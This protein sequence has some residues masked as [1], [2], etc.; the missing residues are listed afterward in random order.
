MKLIPN[1]TRSARSPYLERNSATKRSS[2][3]SGLGMLMDRRWRMVKVSLRMG[4]DESSG[5]NEELAVYFQ[6]DGFAKRFGS[7]L[8]YQIVQMA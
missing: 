5:A 4:G 6:V 3:S 1:E 2:L 7:L 8:F